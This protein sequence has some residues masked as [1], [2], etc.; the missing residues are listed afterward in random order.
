MVP[1]LSLLIPILLS[2]VLVFIASSIIHM[3]TKFHKNDFSKVPNEDGLMAAMR[4]FNLAPGDYGMP[5]ASSMAAMGTPEFKEKMKAGPV[6]FMTVRPGEYN[7]TGSLIQWFVYSIVVSVFA[8][9]VAGVALGPGTEYLK[10]FQI[11]G[12]VAFTGYAIALP[13][14]SIWGGKNWG[15]TFRSMFDGLLY[16]LLTGGAFGWLWPN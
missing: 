11:A 5:L 15:S 12:C 1:L 7:M 3:F 13:Q 16:G 4:P 2:A 10:V 9:Y 14:T 6:V 8:G